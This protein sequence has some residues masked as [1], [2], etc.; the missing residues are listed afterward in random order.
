MCLSHQD[1]LEVFATSSVCKRG[2]KLVTE[3]F[4]FDPT[5]GLEDKASD[6]FHLSSFFHLE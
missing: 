2:S 5:L 4:V 1:G 3:T 6:C